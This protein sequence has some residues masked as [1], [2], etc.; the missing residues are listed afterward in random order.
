M[1]L[2]KTIIPDVMILE[3]RVYGD[4]RGFFL[5]IYRKE[6]F[7]AAGIHDEFVQDNHSKSARGVLRGL[8][9]Q[10]QYPQ[11]KLVRVVQGEIFDV[12]VDLRHGSPSFG[13]WAGELLS[14]ENKR[15]LWVPPGFAHGF[16]VLSESAEVIYKCTTY[17]APQYERSLLWNDPA[18]G[19]EWPSVPEVIL[20]DKDRNAPSLQQAETFE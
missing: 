4:H 14:A 1:Q 15:A 6:I 17:Y 18:L 16:L 9:Y 20:S 2:I 8:H 13:Q 11:G 5:E 10:L 7:E 12:A 3:P 19:I